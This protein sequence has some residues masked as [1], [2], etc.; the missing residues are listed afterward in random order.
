MKDKPEKN[1][2]KSFCN[3]DKN[4]KLCDPE[5]KYRYDLFNSRTN[6]LGEQKYKSPMIPGYTGFYHRLRER[7]RERENGFDWLFIF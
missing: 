7:E 4:I 5:Y 1:F 6:S 2:K 3:I